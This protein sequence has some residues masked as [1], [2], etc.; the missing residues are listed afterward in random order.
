MATI[1]ENLATAKANYAAQL[2]EISAS[3]KPSYSVAGR[4]FSWAEYQRF[5]LEQ[6]ATIDVQLASESPNEVYIEGFS[7]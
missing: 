3:P 7:A 2:A 1:A 4:S 5:L 6:M